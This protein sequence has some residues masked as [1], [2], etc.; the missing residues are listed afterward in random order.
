MFNITIDDFNFIMK[1]SG[2]A[3]I[4]ISN[5]EYIGHF[6]TFDDALKYLKDENLIKK[7]KPNE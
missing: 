5:D 2:V 4:R 1:N 7:Y 6:E 3:V